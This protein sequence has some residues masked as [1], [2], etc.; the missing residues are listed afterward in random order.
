MPQSTNRDGDGGPT[1]SIV[2]ATLR[3]LLGTL[4]LREQRDAARSAAQAGSAE[5]RARVIEQVRV[6]S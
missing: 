2:S 3:W 5:Q 6:G 4:V 1:I